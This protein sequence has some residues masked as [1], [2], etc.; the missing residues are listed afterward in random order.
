MAITFTNK[1]AQEL[2][3]RLGAMLGSSAQ[4]IWAATFHSACCRIL[5]RDIDKLGYSRSFTIYDS[6]DS[7]TVMKRIIKDLGIDD[8]AMPA[9]YILSAIS[10]A[11]DEMLC[12]KAFAERADK[13]GDFRK[14]RLAKAYAE[15]EKRLME[16]SA[17][18]FD[19]LILLTVRLLLENEEV[20]GYYQRLFK[21]VLVDEYQDTNTSN[22][23][24]QGTSRAGTGIYAS[25]ATMTRAFINSA[26]R[27]LKTS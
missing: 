2:K 27:R 24:W 20:R 7:Q 18:D 26:A 3:S 6:D 1:A 11:K 4:E 16:A 9:K 8:K 17:L 22:T 25:W 5:R 21:Y 12:A 10:R 19:D 15:Y 13:S 14:Q 23:F